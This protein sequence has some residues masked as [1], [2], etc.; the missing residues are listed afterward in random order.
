MKENKIGGGLYKVEAE[1]I[2]GNGH[3]IDR[4]AGTLSGTSKISQIPVYN[5]VSKSGCNPDDYCGGDATCYER[6]NEPFKNMPAGKILLPKMKN[7]GSDDVPG[8]GNG[9]KADENPQQNFT[10][11]RL[12]MKTIADNANHQ[13]HRNANDAQP[14]IIHVSQDEEGW[15]FLVK[16]SVSELY[17]KSSL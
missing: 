3:V 15:A 7:E 8:N 6:E 9:N 11:Q 13:Q 2:E 1:H 5:Q 4:N 17:M 10:R 16:I 14:F 12:S